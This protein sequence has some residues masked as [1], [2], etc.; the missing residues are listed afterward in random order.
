MIWTHTLNTR[1]KD[2]SRQTPSCL[3][4]QLQ[5]QEKG[6]GPP[7]E[8][9]RAADRMAAFYPVL[10]RC[11]IAIISGDPATKPR[12]QGHQPTFLFTQFLRSSSPLSFPFPLVT[13]LHLTCID[14]IHLSQQWLKTFWMISLIGDSI[15]F[16]DPTFWSPRIGPSAPGSKLA[17]FC[18]AEIG[19]DPLEEEQLS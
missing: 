13:R 8:F 18:P 3:Q 9:T 12:R 17:C 19:M 5:Q 10:V 2:C 16:E 15:L 14:Y 7:H 6:P 1:I 4:L 11:R